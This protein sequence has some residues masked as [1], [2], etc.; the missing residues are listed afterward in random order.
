LSE[1]LPSIFIS[2]ALIATITPGPAIMLVSLNSVK[3]GINQAILTIFGNITG[4]FVMS[5][6]A[7]LGLSTVILYS[8][9]AFLAVKIIGALYLLYL[10]VKLWRS[11]LNLSNAAIEETVEEEQS[12]QNYR[13]Y[14]QGLFISLSNPKAIAFTT[15]LFPQFIDSRQ[16]LMNQFLIL[17]LIFMSLS[18]SCLLSYAILAIKTKHHTSN[19]FARKLTGK[20]FGAIFIGSGIA[21][22]FTSQNKV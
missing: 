3:Y 21:L 5:L 10:G 16:P 20:V 4:L 17:V 18:F 7:V 22:A 15:A 12:P 13:L 6:L 8:A 14:L 11:G 19:I 1:K 2:I 9:P